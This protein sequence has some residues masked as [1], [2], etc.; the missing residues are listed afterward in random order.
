MASEPNFEIGNSD[1]NFTWCWRYKPFHSQMLQKKASS[2]TWKSKGAVVTDVRVLLPIVS[3]RDGGWWSIRVDGCVRLLERLQCLLRR[4]WLAPC[5]ASSSGGASSLLFQHGEGLPGQISI[6]RRHISQLKS[7]ITTA[8]R[9][10][11][12]NYKENRTFSTEVNLNL[13]LLIVVVYEKWIV[14]FIFHLRLL[15]EHTTDDSVNNTH[16]SC[17]FI[18]IMA[19]YHLREWKWSI[20]DL[21][22]T[23]F[24]L[25]LWSVCFRFSTV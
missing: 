20:S 13:I 8:I 7:T 24:G 19:K 15:N 25:F 3:S 6:Q 12:I 1:L 22:I 9:Q 16:L 21:Q 11:E 17:R 2:C 10:H 4:F 18:S 5:Q 23:D 14:F